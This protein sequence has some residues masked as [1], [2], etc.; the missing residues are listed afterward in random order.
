MQAPC[1][2]HAIITADAGCM[3]CVLE[4]LDHWTGEGI[5]YVNTGLKEI[6]GVVHDV[7]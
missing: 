4:A 5:R 6:P 2:G 3:E 1:T 7:A